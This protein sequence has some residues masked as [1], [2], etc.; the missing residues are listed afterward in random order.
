MHVLREH[1]KISLPADFDFD[2]F[3]RYLNGVW[4]SRHL[5]YDIEEDQGGMS[6]DQA[7]I[8]F[9]RNN[10]IKAGQ[11]V[12]YIQYKGLN[13]SIYPKLFQS[14][15]QEQIPTFYKHLVYWLSYC[16]RVNFPFNNVIAELDKVDDFP[17]ALIYF[18][19]KRSLTLMQ[20]APYHQ[21]EVVEETLSDVKGKLLINKYINESLVTGNFHKLICEHEPLQFD[22][23]LNRIIK[24]VA[25]RLLQRCRFKETWHL[26]EQILFLLE[27][28]SDVHVTASDCNRVRL[29]PIFGDYRESLDMCRFFLSNDQIRE[30]GNNNDHFCFLLPMNYIFEDYI[31]GFI[32]DKFKS[33]FKTLYQYGGW[34]TDQRV[35][36]LKNDL[37]LQEEEGELLLIVDTKYKLRQKENAK[38]GISQSDM[39]QMLAYALRHNC[40]KVLLLYPKMFGEDNSEDHDVFTITASV[41]SD[42]IIIFAADVQVCSRNTSNLDCSVY[43]QLDAIFNQIL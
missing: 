1:N 8:T 27:D 43:S 34:L 6:K 29:N 2:G 4:Q 21:F 23:L 39:Y 5:Y 31:S 41:K 18:F 37:I 36:K 17:E 10:E 12:G 22:N 32:E 33:R 11:H 13:L 42:P 40:S 28:V 19:A 30:L 9:H 24:S 15:D 7:F 38:R 14:I 20:S 16:R 35:F 25:R 26:L 3:E